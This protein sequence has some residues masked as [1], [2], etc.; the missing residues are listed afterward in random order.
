MEITLTNWPL[1]IWNGKMPSF[2]FIRRRSKAFCVTLPGQHYSLPP[3]A[4]SVCSS[5]CI[6]FRQHERSTGIGC[7][8]TRCNVKPHLKGVLSHSAGLNM[9]TAAA[10]VPSGRHNSARWP[11]QLR[12][13]RYVRA[14][15]SVGMVFSISE[16][17][18]CG[19]KRARW[20]SARCPAP[21][22]FLS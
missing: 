13:F 2:R 4:Q 22:A 10:K 12:R 5:N 7:F 14:W 1:P 6:Y 19:V 20:Y 3:T 11:R 8:V 16:T 21:R 15:A 17:P 18:E 9:Y